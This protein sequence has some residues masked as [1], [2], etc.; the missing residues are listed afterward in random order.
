[1]HG[2]HA[3]VFPLIVLGVL[4]LITL[5]IDRTVKLPPMKL[6]GSSRHDVDY[7][8]EN[9]VTTKTD[10]NGNLRNVLAATQMR[11]YPDNDSTELERPRFTQYG[12]NKPYT[13]IEGQKG[14]VSANGEMVEFKGNVTIVRQAFEGRGEMRLKTDYLKIFPNEDKAETDRPVFIT[15][16]PKTVITGTGMTYDKT[17][18]SFTLN[19]RVRVHYES[20]KSAAEPLPKPAASAKVGNNINNKVTKK[21]TK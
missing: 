6:D 10:I 1:M 12:E 5:W 14:L 7:F 15:Q 3:I 19:Q 21:S 13:Q 17:S 2:R 18:Q 9:F 4:A 8:L 16:D 11:H 20:P